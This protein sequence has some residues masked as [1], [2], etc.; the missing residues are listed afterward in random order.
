METVNNGVL[1]MMIL[2]SNADEP[3]IVSL[4]DDSEIEIAITEHTGRSPEITICADERITITRKP[5][6]PLLP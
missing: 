2:V 1:K 3:I 5:V 4:D 6:D